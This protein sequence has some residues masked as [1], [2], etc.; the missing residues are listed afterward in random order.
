MSL[1]LQ[2]KVNN[3]IND[4]SRRFDYEKDFNVNERKFNHDLTYIKELFK[5]FLSQSMSTFV[6]FIQQF[7]ILSIKNH[8]KIIIKS[9]EKIINLSAFARK[10]KEVQ[11]LKKFSIADE[12]SQ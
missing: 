7:K 10:I 2:K 5:N 3:F 4:S 1:N 11:T 9:F 6:I 12:K 8:K